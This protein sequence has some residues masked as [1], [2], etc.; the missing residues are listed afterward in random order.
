MRILPIVILIFMLVNP[1][2]GALT[3][4]T[5]STYRIFKCQP[6]T[7]TATF[8]GGYVADVFVNLTPTNGYPV[9]SYLMANL[10]GGSY[11]YTY[12]NDP[13]LHWGN[14]SISYYQATGGIETTTNNFT[15]VYSDACT[16]ANIG[17]YQNVS[18]RQSGFGNYTRT[19][20]SGEKNLIEFAVQPY[21]NYFGN[22]IYLI[23]LFGFCGIL[24]IKNQHIIQPLMLAFLGLTTLALS[25]L[26]PPSFKTFVLLLMAA[27]MA[28]IFYKLFKSG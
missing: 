19:L 26:V 22:L 12:G 17:G 15:F 2:F 3:S 6:V 5:V 27:S 10:G 25:S 23:M 28:A 7:Y 21:L 20:F 14:K 4:N 18:Y 11:S 13:T 24:Y 8:D 16:G 9:E 1:A